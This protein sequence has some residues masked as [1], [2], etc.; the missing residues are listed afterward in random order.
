MRTWLPIAL[1]SV[2][3][4]DLIRQLS[5]M[6]ESN[7]QYA[8]GWF[9]PILALGLLWK[10]W[11]D[12]PAPASSLQPPPV[13]QSRT[14][15][16]RLLVVVLLAALILL[17]ARVIHEV[18]QD[19]ALFS[20]LL[21]LAVVAFSLYAVFLL[22]GW[23]WVR[24]FAFP[25]CFILVAVRWPYRIENSLTYRLMGVVAT[26][27]VE[28]LGWLGVPAVQHGNVIEVATGTL[29]VDEA[30]SG[31]RSFQSSLMAALF[32]GELYR[33]RVWARAGLVFG[34]LALAFGLN[35]TRTLILSW[36]ADKSGLS[37]IDK[38]H[39]PAG[40]TITIACFVVLW[41]VAVL[42]RKRWGQSMEDGTSKMEKPQSSP[43]SSILHP[44]SSSHRP[45]TTVP[46]F[47]FS[48]FSFQHCR[49]YLV[50]VGCW[51]LL[52]IGV[53]EVW[54]RAHEHNQ[55]PTVAW[56]AQFPTNSPGAR[57]I[58]ISKLARSK[59]NYDHA[60][61]LSWEEPDGSKWSAY[62]FRWN[63]GVATSRMSAR[64]HRPEYCLGG[65]GYNCQAD[66][67]VRY[68]S[69]HGLELPFR[70]Y[71]FERSE[72]VLYVFHCL[73]ED[74]AA[75]QKGFGTSKYLDRLETVLE[76]KRRLGQQTLE[77]IVSGYPDIETAEAAVR[78]RL[79]SLIQFGT[80]P[81]KITSLDQPGER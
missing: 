46:Q 29:G 72:V 21:T 24:H 33:L 60:S 44:P 15:Q 13:N 32:L 7:E 30:C 81:D 76:G 18:N 66:L 17:P 62:C 39:D 8:F 68:L 9:V 16:R 38:W 10:R 19:W 50:A 49:R 47:Q 59:L 28:F 54:Y 20:W 12:R 48:A 26:L 52:C 80:A 67:G 45:L 58:P 11:L 35:V 43:R 61:T 23:P 1:F 22:G 27:T 14:T 77:I 5:Y 73:W 63:A 34:G 65:S 36:Q 4:L 6:W 25:I 78:Q 41:G 51:S 2:L 79:P 31:I 37:V 69:A 70:T 64:D 55:S 71:I 57:E 75:K 40:F 74:G 42:V 53:T 56:W 3:W